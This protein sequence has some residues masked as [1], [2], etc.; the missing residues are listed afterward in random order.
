MYNNF[1]VL[2][3]K[4]I[5]QKE[6]INELYNRGLIELG[7]TSNIIKKLDDDIINLKNK[8]EKQGSMTNVIVKIPL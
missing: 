5:I 6:L 3:M 4:K 1:E 7:N 2:I 8:F